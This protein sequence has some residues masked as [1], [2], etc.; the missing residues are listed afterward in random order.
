MSTV[1]QI[2]I[3][4]TVDAQSVTTELPKAGREF[5]QFG[6]TADQAAAK[7]TRS[8]AQVQMSV[9]DVVAGAGALH[10]VGASLPRQQVGSSPV[11]GR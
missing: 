8:L 11:P 7:A 1:R 9:R 4:M 6:A 10:I 3:R 5:T 2:G